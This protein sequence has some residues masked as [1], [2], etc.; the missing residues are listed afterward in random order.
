M[1]S[2]ELPDDITK[3]L[4][5]LISTTYLDV[6]AWDD[7]VTR[8]SQLMQSSQPLRDLLK[9]IF[10]VLQMD[11]PQ[12]EDIPLACENMLGIV[13]LGCANPPDMLDKAL[14]LTQKANIRGKQNLKN[15]LEQAAAFPLKFP[16]DPTVGIPCASCDQLMSRD[17]AM[18]PHCSKAHHPCSKCQKP[19]VTD[20]CP[21]CNHTQRNASQCSKC[22]YDNPSE[23]VYCTKCATSLSPNAVT[24]VKCHMCQHANQ[25]EAK[26]C[27]QCGNELSQDAYICP[28]CGN[29]NVSDANCCGSCG[30]PRRQADRSDTLVN[31]CQHCFHHNR[32]GAKCCS[33]CGTPTGQTCKHCSTQM[34][35]GSKFCDNCGKS[36]GVQVQSGTAP[37]LLCCPSCTTR[38]VVGQPFCPACSADVRH[39]THKAKATGTGTVHRVYDETRQRL[40]DPDKPRHHPMSLPQFWTP[41]PQLNDWSPDIWDKLSPGDKAYIKLLKRI[42]GYAYTMEATQETLQLPEGEIDWGTMTNPQKILGL[43]ECEL[44]VMCKVYDLKHPWKE[45]KRL[46]GYSQSIY[47]P[48]QEKEWATVIATRQKAETKLSAATKPPY[49][50]TPKDAKPYDKAARDLSSTSDDAQKALWARVAQMEEAMKQRTPPVPGTGGGRQPHKQGGR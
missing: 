29:A 41:A 26:C 14:Q 44:H 1:A 20:Q 33:Q 35:A 22:H 30:A 12:P 10:E 47:T 5:N 50:P 42:Q 27:S 19:I 2:I 8:C 49:K 32:A 15:L 4:E 21:F 25:P 3:R 43:V 23:A 16:Y 39:V 13:A 37:Q 36:I 9:A 28:Q 7:L 48:A 46:T 24:N 6:H 31:H 45:A 11:L 38:V 34:A 40:L 18:C 17:A